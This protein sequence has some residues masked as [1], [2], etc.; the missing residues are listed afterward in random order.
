M[1]FANFEEAIAELLLEVNKYSSGV[2]RKAYNVIIEQ[3]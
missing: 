1:G 2:F 3:R